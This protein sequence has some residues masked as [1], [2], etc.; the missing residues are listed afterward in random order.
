[1]A[2]LDVSPIIVSDGDKMSAVSP[3]RT[4][5]R[6]SADGPLSGEQVYTPESVDL[7]EMMISCTIVT[8]DLSTMRET[9]GLGPL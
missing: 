3:V 2:S 7:A 6:T 8:S 9:P 4:W 5:S 1:M